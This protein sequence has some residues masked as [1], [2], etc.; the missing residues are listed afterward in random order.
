[1]TP[2]P[3]SPRALVV[4]ALAA[5]VV[6]WASA[7]VA[8]R[9]ALP[10]LGYGGIASGRLALAAVVFGGIALAAG[11]RRPSR[12]ELPVL[13]ALGATG[14][15]GYQLLLSAGERTVPAG[16]AALLLSIAPVLAAVLAGPV[17]G[18]RLG[19]RGWAGLAVALGGAVL[20]ALSQRGGGGLGGALLVAAAATVY[21]VWIV[22]QKR[23][24]RTMGPLHA[25]A[26][27]TWFGAL[28]A[29]PFAHDLPAALGDAT[30]GAVA[31]LLVLGLVLSTVPFLLWAWVLQRM[32]ANL[33][34]PALLTVGPTGVL[35][36]WLLLGEQ[37][38]PLA[39]IGGAVTVAGVAAVQ[40]RG[41][42]RLPRLPGVREPA[43]QHA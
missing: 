20:V 16:T 10:S 39:L 22:V 38:A 32:P 21:A 4:A 26:W 9:E 31:A 6:L 27:G 8:I 41:P 30:G 12:A 25:T 36:G 19:A 18:E 37:P 35:L 1:M 15:A 11:G 23:A 24:L 2:A 43:P 7:F 28:F 42:L 40:L 17:L 5:T 3:R 13:A 34:A 14:Y 29:L 33:A